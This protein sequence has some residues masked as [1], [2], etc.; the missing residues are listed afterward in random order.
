MI[1]ACFM[2]ASMVG[3][4]M[5]PILMKR[6]KPE[7][8]MKYVFALGAVSLMVR[9]V[10]PPAPHSLP[11]SH[12]HTHA[13][14]HTHTRTPP[15]HPTPPHTHTRQVPFMFHLSMTPDPS[16]LVGK[17]A[18]THGLSTEGTIQVGFVT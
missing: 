6:S 18:N 17:P 4:A 13:H 9:P 7:S 2:T 12:A 5:S 16:K 3:S 11:V 14:T 15:P 8:F 1:F 10:P